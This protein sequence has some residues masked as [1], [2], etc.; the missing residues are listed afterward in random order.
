MMMEILFDILLLALGFSVG[1][2]FC[3]WRRYDSTDEEV[4]APIEDVLRSQVSL[5]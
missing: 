4:I 5:N 1:C 2:A 3:I